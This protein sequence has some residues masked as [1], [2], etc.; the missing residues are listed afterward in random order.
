[1]RQPDADKQKERWLQIYLG[2]ARHATREWNLRILGCCYLNVVAIRLLD[3]TAH[4]YG[5][6]IYWTVGEVIGLSQ[7]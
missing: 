4:V 7:V 3:K 2:S 5:D 1:M 6:E